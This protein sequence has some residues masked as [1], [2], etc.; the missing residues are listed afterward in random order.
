MAS[1]FRQLKEYARSL[2]SSRDWSRKVNKC[3][4]RNQVIALIDQKLGQ[5]LPAKKIRSKMT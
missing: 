5:V 1:K 2:D 4:N 3:F